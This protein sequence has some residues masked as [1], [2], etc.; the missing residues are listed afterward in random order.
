MGVFYSNQ[1]AAARGVYLNA[2]VEAEE[3]L[4]DSGLQHQIRAAVCQQNLWYGAFAA[5]IGLPAWGVGVTLDQAAFLGGTA[6][7]EVFVIEVAFFASRCPHRSYC[8]TAVAGNKK[9][10]LTSLYQAN[11]L[12]IHNTV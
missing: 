12:L 5:I 4:A 11:V 6:A 9:R 7:M 1:V 3:A 2:P 10:P 8:I